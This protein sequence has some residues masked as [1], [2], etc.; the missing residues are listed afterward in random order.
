MHAQS[1]LRLQ[2]A[3]NVLLLIN[4]VDKPVFKLRLHF[5]RIRLAT[6]TTKHTDWFLFHFLGITECFRLCCTVHCT[7]YRSQGLNAEAGVRCESFIGVVI[8]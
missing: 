7:A 4:C 6:M 2:G 1:Q 3:Y 5:L 8:S